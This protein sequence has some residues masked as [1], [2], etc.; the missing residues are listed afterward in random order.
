MDHLLDLQLSFK[1]CIKQVLK[2]PPS[3]LVSKE[4]SPVKTTWAVCSIDLASE[5]NNISSNK[6][7]V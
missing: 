2:P 5:I 4:R 6:E 7:K 1:R 3:T